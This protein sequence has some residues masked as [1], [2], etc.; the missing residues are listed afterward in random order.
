MKWRYL[1]LVVFVGPVMAQSPLVKQFE[2][3]RTAREAAQKEQDRLYSAKLRTLFDRA[4]KSG[5]MEA[6]SRLRAELDKL[7]AVLAPAPQEGPGKIATPEDLSALL[8]STKKCEWL[9]RDGSVF[10]NFRFLPA[11]KLE[12]PGSMDWLTKW[13]A[14][15]KDEFRV[16]HRDGFFWFFK[17]S[18]ETGFAKSTKKRGAAQDESKAIRLVKDPAP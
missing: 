17:L 18:E 14:I 13:E 10:G 9:N 7:Q 12:L 4:E 5:D 11:G 8:I 16:Y 2:E 1:W 15:S 3:L 6:K